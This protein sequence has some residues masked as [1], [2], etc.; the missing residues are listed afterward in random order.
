M[1]ETF[2]RSFNDVDE[3]YVITDLCYLPNFSPFVVD[4]KK[5]EE[6]VEN[7]REMYNEAFFSTDIVIVNFK[8]KLV[9]VV[10]H[11]GKCWLTK[12]D[13]VTDIRTQ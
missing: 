9:W 7:F 1:R 6:F 10:F 4:A 11:E 3:L 13:N 8:E 12:L 2:G 5:I